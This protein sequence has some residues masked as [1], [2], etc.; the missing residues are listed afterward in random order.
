MKTLK[1]SLVLFAFT[2]LV[3]TSCKKDEGSF[4]EGDEQI[5]AEQN[6]TE[7]TK[8]SAATLE[9]SIEV[10]G[11]TKNTGTPP[12]PNS[13]LDFQLDTS[14]TEAF[15]NSGLTIGFSSNDNIAGAYIQLK[16]VD[17][18]PTDSYFN[19][20]QFSN[21][22]ADKK[23]KKKL[24]FN[25]ELTDNKAKL[26]ENKIDI[27][28]GSNIPAG[29]FCYDIC[30]YDANNNISQIQTVCVTVE[31]WGGNAALVG[32]WVF[33]RGEPDNSDEKETFN[34]SNGQSFEALYSLIEN[35]VISLKFAE[36]G[37]YTENYY[38][39]DRYLDYSASTS[40]CSAIYDEV[41][42]D[43]YKLTGNWAYNVNENTLTVVQFK[44]EDL[45]NGSEEVFQDGELYFEG[46]TV[47]ASN[48]NQLILSYSDFGENFKFYFN[49]K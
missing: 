35:E 4:I 12:A 6:A 18:T 27:N 9:S 41:E 46:F 1:L 49:R 36:D 14:K 33:D 19:V 2:F 17:G 21:K 25:S 45:V 13:N 7:K 48:N 22:T 34:C 28:F 47:E 20:S 38:S 5:A 43:N 40:S 15:Q 26:T 24:F 32:E 42:I 16:D 31:A 44:F 10:E 29:Q 3:F 8:I 39:E 23:T 37:T 11:A 30:L